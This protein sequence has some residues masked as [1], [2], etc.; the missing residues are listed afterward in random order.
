M[1]FNIESWI[2]VII[3]TALSLVLSY[4]LDQSFWYVFFWVVLWYVT[5][6]G[7]CVLYESRK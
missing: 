3:W 4:A 1:I 5:S 2:P 7:A 6:H